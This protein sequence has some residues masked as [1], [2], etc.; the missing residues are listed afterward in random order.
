M[1]IL[2][3]DPVA[4]DN[5]AKIAIADRI[6]KENALQEKVGEIAKLT[7]TIQ[8]TT[9]RI[10][11]LQ[12]AIDSMGKDIKVAVDE[13]NAKQK[14]LVNTTD[15]LMNAVAERQR[16]EKLGRELAAQNLKLKELL[17]YNKT[18]MDKSA[19]PPPGTRGMVTAVPRQDE[20]EISLGADDGIRKGHKFIV[21]RPSTGKYISMIDVVRVDDPNRA[22]CRPDKASQ[23]DQIQKGDQ[24]DAYTKAR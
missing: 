6:A 17:E 23:N 3:C 12:T 14:E 10:A 19:V 1:R 24:V 4:L 13:R 22:V 2:F 18:A 21:T 15:Q 9:Q 5:E 11:V 7:V 8:E 20:V 16:L